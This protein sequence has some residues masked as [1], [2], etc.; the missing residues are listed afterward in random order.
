MTSNGPLRLTR[1]SSDCPRTA[2]PNTAD[3]LQPR[4]RRARCRPAGDHRRRFPR[5]AAA[6]DPPVRRPRRRQLDAASSMQVICRDDEQWRRVLPLRHRSHPGP[7][8]VTATATSAMPRT[9]RSRA[10]PGLVSAVIRSRTRARVTCG[11]CCPA[12]AREHADRRRRPASASELLLGDGRAP[13]SGV[14][15]IPEQVWENADL[16]ASPFGTPPECASI[17]FENGKAAGSAIPADLVGGAVRPAVG[18]HPRRR[19]HRD[20]GGHHR[21]LHQAHPGRNDAHDHRARGQRHLGRAG[22]DHRQHRPRLEGGRRRGEHRR[23]PAV[24]DRVDHRR[25]LTARS[26]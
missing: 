24:D 3:H 22:D 26:R 19:D 8:T 11:P 4:Q 1:T 9:A 21:A 12:S 15:L 2:I 5:A 25:R 17:G 18:E 7:R 20:A 13:A 10:S 14:G 16:P 6:R 23:Q